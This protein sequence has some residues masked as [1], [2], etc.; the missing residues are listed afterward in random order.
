MTSQAIMPTEILCVRFLTSSFFFLLQIS[1]IFTKIVT[2]M[3]PW[4]EKNIQCDKCEKSFRDNFELKCHVSAVHLKIRFECAACD[5]KFSYECA[6]K[7]HLKLKKSH[8]LSKN[9]SKWKKEPK[10]VEEFD[11]VNCNEKDQE[12]RNDRPHDPR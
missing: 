9:E 12:L 5:K 4:K 7:K 1:D 2:I 8:K 10:K 6:L 3:P 11:F